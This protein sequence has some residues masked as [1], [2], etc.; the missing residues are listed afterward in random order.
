MGIAQG[1]GKTV[2][3]G[4]VFAYDVNDN[5]NSFVGAPGQ[6]FATGPNRSFNGP[7]TN[8]FDNGKI[9]QTNGYTETVYI[10]T[11]GYR[12]VETIEN[13]NE[14]DGYGA[15]GNFNCCMNIF[16]YGTVQWLPNTT[17]TYQI[18]YRSQTGYTHPNLMYHYEF[19]ANGTYLTEYGV[20]TDDI[21]THLGDGWYHAW[22]TFTTHPE[23]AYGFCGMWI[24]EYYGRNKIQLAAVS[25]VPGSIIRPPL[26]FIDENTTRSTTQ[27]LLD[28][29]GNRLLDLSTVS[30]NSGAQMI[31]DGT[32]DTLDTGIP[33]TDFPALSNFTIECIAKIDQ[34]PTAAPANIYGNS[35]RSGVLV[36]A[37]YYSGTAL[38]WYG[39][40]SGTACTIYSY[41]R[42]AD[43]YRTA[44]GFNMTPGKY[45]HLVLVNNN[46]NS[47]IYLYADG[48][49]NGSAAGPTQQYNEGLAGAAGNIGVAKPQV[50]GGGE[51]N[52]SHLPVEV[53][54]V[55]LYNRALS[56][57]EIANNYGHYK[58]RFNL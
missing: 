5:R 46:G 58:S 1:F 39:N 24:Y 10:P 41:I 7:T 27:S 29:T 34:Y 54:V 13:Y 9:Y 50:D 16:G 47:T 11:L 56:P 18:I 17:Y 28:L 8:T 55:K 19:R 26:Q 53:P 36:G 15:N 12:S 35:T 52:Y 22:N 21:R 2:T 30:F 3:N 40:S 42:G 45:H 32:D 4:L 51:A 43:A 38:Y 23:A 25:I 48:V 20:H 44:G 14:Y 33:L 57:V 37:A 6:N 31:F 49:Q